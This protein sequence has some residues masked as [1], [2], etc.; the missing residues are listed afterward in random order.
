MPYMIV[1][2]EGKPK[3]YSVYI[4]GLDGRPKGRPLGSHATRSG[5]E[6]QIAAVGANEQR[7][8]KEADEF[9]TLELRPPLAVADCAAA[10]LADADGVGVALRARELGEVLAAR[11]MVD[12]RAVRKLAAFFSDHPH[13]PDDAGS[14]ADVTWRLYGGAA[15]AVW[16]R[17]LRDAMAMD[18]DKPMIKTLTTGNAGSV[19]AGVADDQADKQFEDTIRGTAKY[20]V[21]DEVFV[22][23]IFDGGMV[24]AVRRVSGGF[25]YTVKLTDG[26]FAEVMAADISRAKAK[27]VKNEAAAIRACAD[28]A[29][30]LLKACV[31]D[32]SYD[33]QALAA[34]HTALGQIEVGGAQ[35]DAVER[36]RASIEQAAFSALRYTKSG[37]ADG[38]KSAVGPP[39]SMAVTSLR[40]AMRMAPARKGIAN[41]IIGTLRLDKKQ[42]RGVRFESLLQYRDRLPDEASQALWMVEAAY[43][44]GK[45]NRVAQQRLQN[46]TA[47]QAAMIIE[48]VA[49][50]GCKT[51]DEAAKWINESN[52]G[53][54]EKL[55]ERNVAPA[56]EANVKPAPPRDPATFVT[57][58]R[59]RLAVEDA[60]PI[61]FSARAVR[62]ALTSLVRSSKTMDRTTFQTA[63]TP[64]RRGMKMVGNEIDPL[65]A[66]A[67]ALAALDES[68]RVLNAGSGLVTAEGGRVEPVKA[69]KALMDTAA[70]VKDR[71][72]EARLAALGETPEIVRAVLQEQ[73]PGKLAAI[74]Q[75]LY[76]ETTG[77][78]WLTALVAAGG[79][80]R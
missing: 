44:T 13:A 15:G 37:E 46:A 22:K 61:A 35:K 50:A 8:R 16:A 67:S 59:E 2:R 68:I 74:E 12:A 77:D 75:A 33:R 5:A 71:E 9:R 63:V 64:L 62:A 10:A 72:P 19:G 80:G 54:P 73:E 48:Q 31:D 1:E 27:A 66:R 49:N 60:P 7:A 24:S 78:E 18:G 57:A 55:R 56:S 76:A 25:L 6:A 53:Q 11:E 42:R 79:D 43:Q 14:R 23:S 41:D 51:P 29:A 58:A 69:I 30:K 36:A 4:R 34:L 32:G 20:A 26:G 28:T 21:G 3:P 45:L 70:L 52:Y 38:L 47:Y 17:N 39:L 65:R 40:A